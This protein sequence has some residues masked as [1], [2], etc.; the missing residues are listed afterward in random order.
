MKSGKVY[1][2]R[3]SDG[4]I[5]IGYTANF[6]SRLR[7][8]TKAH[9]VLE[10]LRVLNG[11]RFRERELHGRFVQ[12]NEFG[13]W[14]R[15][16]PELRAAIDTEP[17]GPSSSVKKSEAKKA[18][19]EGENESARQATALCRK[20]LHTRHQRTGL[21][22]YKCAK[23]IAEAYG[24]GL[25]ALHNINAGKTSVVTAFMMKRLNEALVDEMLAFRG[26]LLSEIEK[27]ELAAAKAAA[28]G[29]EG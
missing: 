6:E 20:L 26:D 2:L 4:L 18:W 21:A 1:F 11:D 24:F 15:D 29:K 25:N 23:Q 7:S 8:L 28:Q 27:V 14:F 3:R 22:Y 17:E 16:S 19:R 12:H 10:I 13:E 5:K 9:G